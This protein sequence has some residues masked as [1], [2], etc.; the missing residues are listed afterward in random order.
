MGPPGSPWLS[1]SLSRD[2]TLPFCGSPVPFLGNATLPFCED[3]F[4]QFPDIRRLSKESGRKARNAYL[5]ACCRKPGEGRSL[6]HHVQ[7]AD[8]AT[9]PRAERG[10]PAGRGDGGHPAGGGGGGEGEGGEGEGVRRQLQAKVS[11]R[12]VS[13][14]VN[15]ADRWSAKPSGQMTREEQERLERQRANK[16]RW[17]RKERERC[18]LEM[19]TLRQT[20]GDL[21]SRNDRLRC[22]V[23]QLQKWKCKMRSRLLDHA[24]VMPTATVTATAPATATRVQ[25][26]HA[27]RKVKLTYG[28]KTKR[29]S[30]SQP[31]RSRQKRRA[32]WPGGTGPRPCRARTCRACSHRERLARDATDVSAHPPTPLNIDAILQSASLASAGVTLQSP[33]SPGPGRAAASPDTDQP[34]VY[35]TLQAVPLSQL[36]GTGVGADQTL[37]SQQGDVT[38]LPEFFLEMLDNKDDWWTDVCDDIFSDSPADTDGNWLQAA[39]GQVS[40]LGPAPRGD[41]GGVK[42]GLPPDGD[43]SV[44]RPTDSSLS[45]VTALPEHGGPSAGACGASHSQPAHRLSQSEGHGGGERAVVL[46][47][48]VPRARSQMGTAGSARTQPVPPEPGEADAGARRRCWSQDDRVSHTASVRDPL[49]QSWPGLPSTATHSLA[50]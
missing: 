18:R 28:G 30:P 48:V 10:R 16:R 3:I 32:E 39:D 50:A 26:A 6:T 37:P 12:L 49:S 22:E 17:A 25:H 20:N 45:E 40:A 13:R 2:A 44:A 42:A 5:P 27:P 38:D 4:P 21:Q 31:E 14:G 34:G 1:C 23:D 41:R 19:E 43:C 9:A 46:R 8:V 15:T 29:A 11:H 7:S 35:R 47:A 33:D 24:C 36:L